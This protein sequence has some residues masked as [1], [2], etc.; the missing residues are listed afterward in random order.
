M[1]ILDSI[2]N[3]DIRK[4]DIKTIKILM[5]RNKCELPCVVPDVSDDIKQQ[6]RE[7]L[8]DIT[9][10]E[11]FHLEQV[12]TLGDKKYMSHGGLDI[13]H[14]AIANMTRVNKI[15][16]EYELAEISIQNNT[17]K[18]GDTE[19]QYKTIEKIG[20]NVEYFFETNATDIHCDKTLIEILTAWK[21]LRGR[22]ENTDAIFKFMPSEFTPEDVRQVYE[23]IS[24]RRVDKSNFHKRI[25]KYCIEIPDK[26]THRGHRPGKMYKFKAKTGDAWL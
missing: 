15:G 16:P 10:T 20:Y 19:Y 17:I 18:I 12:Y 22:L 2:P 7:L 9:G 26:T 4:N 11:L 24:Q 21:Y 5:R 1:L 25:T 14:L 3:P 13:I 6:M 8:H 23:T